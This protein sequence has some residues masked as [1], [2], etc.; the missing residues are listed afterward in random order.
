MK[1]PIRIEY[2]KYV[3]INRCQKKNI[4]INENNF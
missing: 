2:Y 1:G 3:K 4:K